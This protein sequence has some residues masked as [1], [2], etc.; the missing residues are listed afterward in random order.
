M[1]ANIIRIDL[2]IHRTFHIQLSLIA[3]LKSNYPILR[4]KYSVEIIRF[5]GSKHALTFQLRIGLL[6][7]DRVDEALIENLS[8]GCLGPVC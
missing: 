6:V 3:P 2:Y 5:C 7:Y 8:G 4:Y 1:M